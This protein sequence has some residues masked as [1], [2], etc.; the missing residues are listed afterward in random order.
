MQRKAS[1][2]EEEGA[3]EVYEA[4]RESIGKLMRMR[5]KEMRWR[6]QVADGGWMEA[7]KDQERVGIGGQRRDRR[8]AW[9]RKGGEEGEGEGEGEGEQKEEGHR[10]RSKMAGFLQ[11]GVLSPNLLG[12]AIRK[13]PRRRRLEPTGNPPTR[14]HSQTRPQPTCHDLTKHL[15]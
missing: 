2:E 5:A 15:P 1:G 13:L 4:V 10:R 12:I 7:G 11:I 9:L 14:T 8:K 3:E 6:E